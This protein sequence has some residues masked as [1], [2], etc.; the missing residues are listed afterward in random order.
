[1]LTSY[2]HR[3]GSRPLIADT[4][5]GALDRAAA[6]WGGRTAL[7]SCH[8]DR[9]YT[10]EELRLAAN[11]VARAFMALGVER[12]DRVGI[13]S[14][15]NAEWMLTQYAAA[16]AGAILVN[17][18]PAY[19]ARELEYALNHSGI[20]VLITSRAFRKTDYVDMLVGLMPEL[21]STRPGDIVEAP[22]VPA[23][24]HV[25]YLGD[26]PT[27]GGIAWREL[28]GLAEQVPERALTERETA[29]QFDD[30]VNI[31]YTSGTTGVPKGA[32]LSHHNILNNGLFVGEALRY[33]ERDRICLPVP[34]YHCFGCVLGTLAAVT[35]GCAIVLPG[36]AFDA[37][38]TLRAI[39]THGCTSIYGVPTMFI[40]LLNVPTFA[41]YRL[42]SLRTG[43]MAGAPCPMDVMRSV[44]EN[45]HVEEITI[46]YGMTE[47]APVSFQSAVDDPVDL[48]VS[49]V[50]QV[51]PHVECKIVDPETGAVVPRGT[52]GELC[53][54]G[55]LVMLGYWNSPDETAEAVDAAGWMHSGDLAIMDEAGYVS[56]S[57]RIKD[58]IIRGGENVYPREI[59][60]FL[61]THS[62]ISEV[63][64]VGVPDRTYGEAVC[65][66]IRLRP[67][68]SA[69]LD[70]I[71]EFCRGQ[72]ATYKIPRY[73]R[74]TEEFP[75]TVTGKIQ[76]FRMREISAEELGLT[77]IV[78]TRSS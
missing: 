47:T 5:G 75:M 3:G 39:D 21:E 31:Q 40:A 66:W 49:T 37:E 25:I 59:E 30:A 36:E 27:P 14:A 42:D 7:T 58:M 11:A 73:V 78:P 29:L 62:N 13:W 22:R 63:Q 16:K 68:T 38:A 76:K 74:F 69:S 45:M 51:H 50:G 54:R 61:Y 70:E 52:A 28:A 1:M 64:V 19:R 23:L 55:Y 72:I 71:R 12:G 24:R 48:R 46:C 2:V 53:T 60:E 65:A 4:I 18:N 26:N 20:S 41:A 32:T 33:T 67:G 10:Y 56:I 34:F 15:N 44:M 35:H 77:D 17:L 43:I 9:S 57:G 6:E 8:Q